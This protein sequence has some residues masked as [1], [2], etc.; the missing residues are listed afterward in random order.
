MSTPNSGGTRRTPF[1]P[2][3]LLQLRR[4]LASIGQVGTMRLL[5][6]SPT[7]LERLLAGEASLP[8][9]ER[10]AALLARLA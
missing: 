4:T 1:P 7:T 8:T 3:A 2:D 10:V 5:R 9:V 6:V